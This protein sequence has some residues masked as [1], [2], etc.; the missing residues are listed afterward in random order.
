MYNRLSRSVR[1]CA[2]PK[3]ERRR[4][5]Y[6]LRHTVEGSINCKHAGLRY[7]TKRRLTIQSSYWDPELKP[8][9]YSYVDAALDAG[10]SILIYDRLGTGQSEQPDAYDIVQGPPQIEILNQLIVLARSGKLGAS[11]SKSQ[12][13][14]VPKFNKVVAV[15][16]SMGSIVTSGLLTR[17]PNAVDGAVLTGFLLSSKRNEDK[18][19]AHGLEFA[20]TDKDKRFHDYPDGYVVQ[21]TRNDVQQ[22][23]FKKG[24]FE[25]DALAYAESVKDSNTVGELIG[26][27]LITGVPAP[28]FSGPMLVCCDRPF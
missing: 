13:L 4:T 22:S 8:E 7:V 28:K 3:M 1:D 10:Y 6:K 19:N 12:Y 2:C 24:H 26:F 17:H 15:G 16:H 25:S 18:Q 21:T 9:K 27:A 14:T 5:H 23:F 11:L 20:R